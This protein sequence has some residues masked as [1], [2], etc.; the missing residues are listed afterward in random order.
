MER[1]QSGQS[2][3]L[4]K[5]GEE[6]GPFHVMLKWKTMVDLDLY[7]FYRLKDEGGQPA[8]PTG[9]L[10]KLF[11]SLTT[12]S[13]EG[14]VYFSKKGNRG[15]APWISLDQ[16][17]GVGDVGGDNEESMHF[18]DLD[19]IEHALIVVNM[20]G[21][22]TN[23]SAYDGRLIVEGGGNKFQVPLTATAR[24]D[25]CIVARID[26]SSGNPQL[27]NVNHTQTM[28]PTLSEWT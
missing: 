1:V 21:K 15:S 12:P 23:F 19:K 25:W 5:N 24:G 4:K 7:C 2:T 28:R 11:A 14:Q 18:W 17:S 8:E 3:Q 20:F 22:T 16:D 6:T 13:K 26:N 9:F 27:H 10:G